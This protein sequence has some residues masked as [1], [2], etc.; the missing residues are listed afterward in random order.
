MRN[1]KAEAIIIIFCG[2]VCIAA[3]CFVFFVANT[4]YPN[5]ESSRVQNLN[6]LLNTFSK[7]GTAIIIAIPGLMAIYA[8]V[9]KLRSKK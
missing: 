9:K 7:T 5:S 1:K 8:G 3:A 2:L 4:I 6:I